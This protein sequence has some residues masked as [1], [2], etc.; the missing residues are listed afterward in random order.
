MLRLWNYFTAV[1]EVSHAVKHFHFE[2]LI[3]MRNATISHLLFGK[4]PPHHISDVNMKTWRMLTDEL[5]RSFRLATSYPLR[6]STRAEFVN[7]FWILR[8]MIDSSPAR[9]SLCSDLLCFSLSED[10]VQRAPGGGRGGHVQRLR[11]GGRGPC[12]GHRRLGVWL[13]IP[14]L[15]HISP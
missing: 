2:V 9:P 5:M 3:T 6:P 13:G 11:A 12:P 10:D 1:S 7:M 4:L 8:H 14:G 15:E